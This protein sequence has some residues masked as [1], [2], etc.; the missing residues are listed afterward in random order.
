MDYEQTELR[1]ESKKSRRPASRPVSSLICAAILIALL[2]AQS[3]RADDGQT[4]SAAATDKA[5][6]TTASAPP[7]FEL[8]L[9]GPKGQPIAGA[10]VN[11]ATQPPL[12]KVRLRAGRLL[13]KPRYGV[14]L[15]S[16]A[17]G[18]IIVEQPSHLE[19]LNF[20]VHKPGYAF[21]SST[22]NFRYDKPLTIKLQKAWTIGGI[23]VDGKGQPVPNARVVLQIRFEGTGQLG[24]SDRLWTNSK[25]VWKF[26]SVPESMQ[27]VSAEVS[28]P[29]YPAHKAS[30][31]R[32]KFAIEPGHEPTGKIVLEGGVTVMGKVT[33]EAGKPIAKALVRARV[34]EDTRTA[35]SDKNGS[36]RLEG[37]TPQL[38]LVA[39]AKG[40][41]AQLREIELGTLEA[42]VDFQL[43]PGKTLRLRVLDEAGR[44]VPK[45]QVSLWGEFGFDAFEVDQ[46]PLKTDLDGAWEWHDLPG[47]RMLLSIHRSNGMT[48][49]WQRVTARQAEYVFR[50]P[51]ELVITGRV[52]DADTKQPIHNFR[53]TSGYRT[54]GRQVVM[55]ETKPAAADGTYQIRQTYL[56]L[57]YLVRIDADGYWHSVSREIKS[58]A[59]NTTIDFELL[60]GKDFA[61][62]VLTPDGRPAAGAKVAVLGPNGVVSLNRGELENQRDVHDADQTGRVQIAAKNNNF[63]LVITHPSGYLDQSGLPSGNPRQLKLTPWA[64]VEGTVH[65]A[66][67]PQSDVDVLLTSP[68]SASNAPPRNAPPR[69]QDTRTTDSSGRFAFD[70]AISGL[71]WI[72]VKRVTGKGKSETTFTATVPVDCPAG[73]IMHVD[74]GGA[75]RPVIGQLRRPPESKS[76]V[77]M[78]SASIMVM[79]DID[80]FD[81]ESVPTFSA[82]PDS[83]GNFSLDEIPPGDYLLHA[84]V[85]GPPPLLLQSH[86]FTVPRVNPKLSQRPV[87]LGVLTLKAPEP[88]AGP[89]KVRR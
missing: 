84:F 77:S 14:N 3:V 20:R 57:A 6:N 43:K 51:S 10:K 40:C 86:H 89:A 68:S 88:F 30:L 54:N 85:P 25:G 49:G 38:K 28:E 78:S 56:Q 58:D 74:V 29:K 35:F 37:C 2:L 24:Y 26:E 23:V 44:P 41:A 19:S 53:F 11:L 81:I 50:V 69:D 70:R 75:G 15:Q 42:S 13:N 80:W 36:Y 61:A 64:R 12:E 1:R 34:G 17:D 45:A 71:H 66:R 47:E 72:I 62:T 82:K 7:V 60:K 32:E 76:D 79:P 63:R 39:A 65:V 5:A 33:D 52:V 8:Q 67:R 16:D 59:G 48:L 73:Q 46:A 18:R 27:L 21:Y 83:D 4:K 9:V 55:N 87:D 31:S 22:Y